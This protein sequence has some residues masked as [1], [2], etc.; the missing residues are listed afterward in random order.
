MDLINGPCIRKFLL[1]LSV[2]VLLVMAYLCILLWSLGSRELKILSVF[3]GFMT[4][5]CVVGVVFG[6]LL[7]PERDY[8]NYCQLPSYFA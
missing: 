2:P 1:V 4:I 7:L 3:W 6:L 8:Y 5:A